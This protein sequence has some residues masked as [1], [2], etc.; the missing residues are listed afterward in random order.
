MHYPTEQRV[1][2]DQWGDDD[3][4]VTWELF[5]TDIPP[6]RN[7]TASIGVIAVDGGMLLAYVAKRAR[8]GLVGGHRNPRETRWRA[9][10]READEEVGMKP[11]DLI[12]TYG[13]FAVCQ[14][15]SRYPIIK[16]ETGQAYPLE[17]FMTFVLVRA[18]AFPLRPDG[19]EVTDCRVFAVHDL[20]ELSPLDQ[21]VTRLATTIPAGQALFAPQ[22]PPTRQA[23][24]EMGN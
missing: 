8:W 11:D 2:T 4:P 19:I 10:L 9:F 14:M 20:P 22:N 17:S 5:R 23:P 7:C 18:K 3:N 1:A 15:R 13:T 16:A 21:A 24:P 6:R 12:A